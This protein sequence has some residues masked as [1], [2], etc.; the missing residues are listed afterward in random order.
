MTPNFTNNSSS[1]FN[2]GRLRPGI[3][4]IQNLFSETYLDVHQHSGVVCCRPVRD[5]EDGRGLVRIHLSSMVRASDNLKW[6]IKGLGVGYTVQRVSL[7]TITPVACHR[8]LNNTEPR[9][10]RE[11]LTSFVLRWR[12]S[13]TRLHSTSMHTLRLGE[14]K[15]STTA[16]IVDL[17][18]SGES[19]TLLGIPEWLADAMY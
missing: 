7:S 8:M 17:N 5:I 4:K 9:L 14:S 6:E 10:T 11:N 1:I 18:T 12:G 16:Y 15:S 2:N 13:T 3:Y 19:W